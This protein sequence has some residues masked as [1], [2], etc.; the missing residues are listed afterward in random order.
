MANAFLVTLSSRASMAVYP[1]SSATMTFVSNKCTMDLNFPAN[2]FG[3]IATINVNVS[4]NP[5][6]VTQSS[7]TAANLEFEITNTFMYQPQKA[8]TVTLHY[9]DADIAGMDELKL[10]IAY[11]DTTTSKWVA[12]PSTADAV[13]NKVTA[14]ISHLTLFRLVMFPKQASLT[15]ADL[16]VYPNPYLPGSTGAFADSLLGKGIVFSGLTAKERILIYTISGE[17]VRDFQET[18]GDG[19]CFWDAKNE[20]NEDVASGVYIYRVTNPDDSSQKKTGK[21]AI[22]R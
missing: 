7:V 15:L 14:D 19:V 4:Q 9:T 22:I 20:G 12:L 8:F 3:N 11:Y 16:Q 13:N 5:A 2:T 6:A 1:S 21:L 17:L 10:V 18:D